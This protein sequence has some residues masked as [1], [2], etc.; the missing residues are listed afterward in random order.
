MQILG[1]LSAFVSVPE[2]RVR[3]DRAF[4]P[5]PPPATGQDARPSLIRIASGPSRPHA[6]FV[7]VRHGDLWYW[8]DDHDLRSKGVFSF[9]LVLM[10]LADSGER[11]PPPQFTIGAN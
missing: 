1:E 2:D 5:A 3:E 6:P 7:A 8:I 10:T 9:L 11:P 4:P